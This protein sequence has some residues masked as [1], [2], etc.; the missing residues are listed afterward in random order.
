[1]LGAGEPKEDSK[2]R[3]YDLG[4]V[5]DPAIGL[6]VNPRS[7]TDVRRAV[8]AAAS[9]S[10]EDKV[11]V[12]RRVVLGAREAGVHRFVV[13]D[14]IHRIVG[15]A[16]ETMRD[17]SLEWLDYR[18]TFTEQ[19]TV[20]AV[21]AMRMRA[22]SVVVVL[23]GDGTNRAAALA[24][25]DLVVVPLSTGTN[26]VFPL[27]VEAT[28]A[29]AAAGYLALGR[30]PVESVAHS[31][32]VVR[33]RRDGAW[34]PDDLALVD[35]VSVEDRHLGSLELFDPST[36]RTAV[37]SRA[38][39]AAV[40][41]AGVGGLVQPLAASEDA[42][43]MIRFGPADSCNRVVRGPIAPG[44][45]A[46]FGLLEVRR[47]ALGEEVRVGGPLLMALDGERKL[48]LASEEGIYLSVVRDGPRVVDVAAVMAYVAAESSQEA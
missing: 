28:V 24:W 13:H 38:D 11:N 47:L 25:P 26:N 9:V 3:N 19:D 46:T 8:A 23:G 12:V 16:T 37:L 35:A 14:D 6:V 36:V 15:R 40:G 29:G 21:A 2:I 5:A 39:P 22:C 7:G 27:F 30:C 43:L 33:I 18:P 1:M 34:E 31:S 20:D 44:S 10:V 48:R 17:L 4:A 45:Y 42:G 41:F 32:A